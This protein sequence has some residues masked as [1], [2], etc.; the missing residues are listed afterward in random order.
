MACVALS[1]SRFFVGMP[2][3]LR[4]NKVDA[5][6][7]PATVNDSSPCVVLPLKRCSTTATASAREGEGSSRRTH[8]SP[9]VSQETC[10]VTLSTT[11]RGDPVVLADAP[12]LSCLCRLLLVFLSTSR[13]TRHANPRQTSRHH[14]YRLSRRR[15]NHLAAAY[16][17]PC[18]WTAH[19]GDRQR[20][21]RA[22]HRRRNPQA[23]LHRLQRRRSQ[24]SHLRAGQ[25][26]S[27]LH[28][29][30][31]ILPGDARAGGTARRARPYP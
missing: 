25:R 8:A 30:G 10:L 31:R 21:R 1:R 6:A 23:V 22:G 19:R 2:M 16:A 24:R 4:G 15:Q 12:W 5:L 3:K 13:R 18:R 27:V 29:A 14:R 20:V 9:V 26:L 7:A 28:R 11:G 17:R